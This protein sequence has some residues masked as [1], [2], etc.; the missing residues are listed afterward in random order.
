ME[1]D[2]ADLEARLAPRVRVMQIIAAAMVGGVLT[3]GAVFAFLA[4]EA[5]PPPAPPAEVADDVLEPAEDP[6]PPVLSYVGLGIAALALLAYKLVGSLLAANAPRQTDEAETA[7]GVYQTRL[8]VRLALLEGAATVCL[9]FL[10]IENWPLLWVA[11]GVL[12][13]AMLSEFPTTAGVRR[14]VES[15]RQLAELNPAERE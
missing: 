4:A 12:I 13:A 9:V 3:I 15:R 8:I 2:L 14:Y 5:G 7:V 1:T 6:D 10:L 11:V